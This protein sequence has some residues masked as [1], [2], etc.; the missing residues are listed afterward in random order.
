MV[1]QVEVWVCPRCSSYYAASGA[2]DLSRLPNR[3]SM[4]RNLADEDPADW[5][6]VIGTRDEC[7]NCKGAGRPRVR[8]RLVITQVEVPEV[9]A[10][11]LVG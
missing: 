11:P 5:S 3:R 8:R 6:A 9:G 10:A 2:G 1:V 4:M 7:Q